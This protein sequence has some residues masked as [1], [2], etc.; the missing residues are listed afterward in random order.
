M[1]GKMIKYL[2]FLG[3]FLLETFQ[4]TLRETVTHHQEKYKLRTLLSS[5]PLAQNR[6]ADGCDPF[7]QLL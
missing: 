4:Q 7:A 6:T 1:H 5:P 3:S 2:V